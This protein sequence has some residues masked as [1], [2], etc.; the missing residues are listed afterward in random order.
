MKSCY[1]CCREII[2]QNIFSTNVELDINFKAEKR[3]YAAF[4][5]SMTEICN[6]M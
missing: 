3:H 2:I 6:Y 1:F 4:C 5:C